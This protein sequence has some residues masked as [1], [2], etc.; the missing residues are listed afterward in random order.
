MNKIKWRLRGYDNYG[1]TAKGI[2]INLTR[3]TTVKKTVK[4]YTKG[5][6]LSGKFKSLSQINSMAYVDNVTV[7]F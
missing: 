1:I 4:G 3:N 6:Y 5:Y 7:P 2:M